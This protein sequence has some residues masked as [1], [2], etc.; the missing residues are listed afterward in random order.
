M[1]DIDKLKTMVGALLGSDLPTQ[2]NIRAHIGQAR[3]ACPAVTDE[4]VKELIRYFETVHGVTMRDGATLQE[5]GFEPWLENARAGL[6]DYYWN[7]YRQLLVKRNLSGQVLATLD[8]VTDRILG[9]LEN[10]TK[11]SKWDRRGMV[12]GHVQSGKTANYTGLICKAA[13]AGYKVIIIIAG[14]HNNLRNQT[15]RRIDEGFIGTDSTRRLQGTLPAQ[16]LVGVGRFGLQRQP[17]AFTTSLRDFNKATAD[18]VQI[19]LQNLKEPVVFV[20]KKNSSTLARLIEWLTAHNVQRGASTVREPMLLI[21]DEADNASINIRRKR[22]EVSR[23]N[24]QIRELLTLFDRRCYVGYTATPFANIFIDPDSEDEMLGHDLFP[25]DFIVSLDPPANYFGA[26]RVFMDDAERVVRAADD[27]ADLL[28]LTHRIH[29]QVTGLPQTLETAVRVFI[30]A[31]AIRLARGHRGQH[32]SMLVNVSRFVNVQN[33]IRNEIHSLVTNI[34]QSVRINGANLPEQ[35]LRDQEISALFQAFQDHYAESCGMPWSDVQQY[36]HDS[37]SAVD[38]V[39]VNSQSPGS[40]DYV[41][42]ETNGLNVIAVGGLSLSRGL[43]LEGL[44]VSYFLRNSMMYDTLLQMGRWFGYRDGY[45]DLC[46]VW[47][48]EEAQGWY[49]HI[50]DSIE[51]LREDLANMQRLNATPREFGLRVRSHPDT[52]VVTARNKMGASRHLRILIGL[53][54]RFVETAILRRD[55]RSL[56]MNRQA[57]VSLA[58]NLRHHGYPPENGNRLN[59]GYLVRNAPVSVVDEFLIGFRNHEGSVKTQI[60]PVRDYIKERRTD[61]LATWDILFAGVNESTSKSCIDFSLGFKVICQRRAAGPRSDDTTLMVTSKQRVSSRGIERAGL[62]EESVRSAEEDYDREHSTGDG[63]ANYPDRI[64]RS[65]RT[66]PLLVVHLLAIG[67][68]DDDLSEVRPVVAWSISFPGTRLEEKK[69]EYV[70]NPTWYREHY[71][72]EDED[73]GDDD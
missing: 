16:S 7:R 28:P 39:E 21:D 17:N 5:V 68:R 2:E 41:N 25:R 73:A 45:D 60:E 47:M 26:T 29:H 13:D 30:V 49:T 20:I 37:V 8:S 27:Y 44:V 31:R 71:G 22:D 59:G 24:G 38:V 69:V 35:A 42:H 50:T 51:E 43:T 65:V 3:R 55:H 54:N 72:D 1:R 63:R 14:I 53:A 64:Y 6:N 56:D 12:M 15:Q 34:R 70:V 19:P 58:G 18:S 9:L 46:R 32:N 48:P 10:P 66:K 33:Q 62:S 4:E 67:D 40:L 23:I 52:L 57:A 11:E 36:L 61:E